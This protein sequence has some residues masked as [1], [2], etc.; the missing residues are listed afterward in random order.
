[1]HLRHLPILLS[2]ILVSSSESNAAEGIPI[3][4]LAKPRFFGTAANTTFLFNDK[5]YTQ[6]AQTQF[7][8]FTP[9]NELKWENVEPRQNVF[10]WGPVDE[11]LDFAKSV[12]ASVRGHTFMWGSQLAPWVNTSLTP[13]QLDA[14][15]ENHI[16]K[17]MTRYK[18]QIYAYD[19][20]NEMISDTASTDYKD[21][22]WTQKLGV[23]ALPKALR[24]ARA[25]DPAAKLYIN[26][27]A[28]EGI[29]TKSDTLYRIVKEFIRDGVPI[30]GVGFQAY[31]YLGA[32]PTTLQE[33]LQ[34]FADLGLDVAITEV[35]INLR[36]PGNTTAFEQ[37]ARDY[38]SIVAACV[39]VQRCV[40]VTAWG[41]M[42]NHSWLPYGYVL[43]WDSAGNPKPAYY[44]IAN[45]FQGK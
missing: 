30:D 7:S 8:I 43:P 36:G 31:H 15:L 4:E 25:A 40:S 12:N 18:G 17:I 24:Y 26:E 34:R 44:A 27:Y 29:N 39:A 14:A 9:E 5:V 2:I 38:H 22:I 42:D 32:V 6:L 1:M 16:T 10:N 41:I 3:R 11:I 19:V 35:D 21:N 28:I 20:I 33:N 37:Q 45:A 23:D 13:A